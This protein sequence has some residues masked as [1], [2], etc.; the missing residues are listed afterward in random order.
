MAWASF[1]PRFRLRPLVGPLT[2]PY[3]FPELRCA[4]TRGKGYGEGN[5]ST[6]RECGL[7]KGPAV[8]GPEVIGVIPL[9]PGVALAKGVG[10]GDVPPSLF[11]SLRVT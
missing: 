4:D 11:L 10:G 3:P 5:S 2:P 7:G 6:D 1:P 8:I 9:N